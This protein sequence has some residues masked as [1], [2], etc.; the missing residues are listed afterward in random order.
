MVF[1]IQHV[2]YSFS[3]IGFIILPR[4]YYVWYEH[5]HGHLPENVVMIGR[6]TTTV[7]GINRVTRTTAATTATTTIIIP[8]NDSEKSN[9]E[10][11]NGNDGVEA[12][13]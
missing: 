7:R 9:D 4:M 6:G 3:A 5:R 12:C 1:T 13:Q 2:L 8:K 10:V 11:A